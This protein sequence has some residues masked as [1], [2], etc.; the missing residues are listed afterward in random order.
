MPRAMHSCLVTTRAYLLNPGPDSSI[1]Q[2]LDRVAFLLFS[3]PSMILL[4]DLVLFRQVDEEI[5]PDDDRD[6]GDEESGRVLKV[7]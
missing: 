7:A 5:T 2:P 1:L 6:E 3:H 4:L